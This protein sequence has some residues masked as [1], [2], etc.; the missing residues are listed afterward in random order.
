MNRRFRTIVAMFTL[1]ALLPACE[2]EIT[3]PPP[4]GGTDA[5]AFVTCT[6]FQ[7]GATTAIRLK[8]GYPLDRNVAPIHNDAV[9]RAFGDFIYVVNRFGADNIQVL[10]PAGGFTTVRQFSVGNGSDPHDIVVVA[11]N[12]AFVSRY[13]ATDLWI[14]NPVTGKKTGFVD[15]SAFADGD[16]IPEM[17]RMT[18]V[19][20]RL[21]VTVQR[22]DRNTDWGPVGESF[23]VVVDAVADTLIDADGATP[24]VQPIVLTAS[25]PFSEIFHDATAQRLCIAG[26]GDW[27][28]EDGGID[29]VGATTLEPHGLI[30]TGAAAGGDITD[31][32]IVAPDRGYAI[33][34]DAAFNT[35]L[36]SFNPQTGTVIAPVYDPRAFV[37][38][39]VE[40]TPDGVLFVSDRSPARPGIRLFDAATGD[41]IGATPLD[42]GLPPFDIEIRAR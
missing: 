18:L 37:L 32:V 40:L 30:L 9:A 19:G 34:T 26:V 6:D 8:E 15:L 17:D 12:K 5:L 29:A 39:D 25:N 27:G 16:G 11:R 24:G 14:V 3:G 36:V 10:D 23:V 1:V 21:F 41:P 28:V 13:N 4:T 33:V 31:V 7:T 20:D 38:Q 22:V 42:T 35:V 2:Q